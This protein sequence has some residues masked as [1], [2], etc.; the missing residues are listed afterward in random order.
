M[1][2]LIFLLTLLLMSSVVYSESEN[3]FPDKVL[4][5][6]QKLHQLLMNN[7]KGTPL[8]TQLDAIILLG[9]LRV[10]RAISLL[11]DIEDK[12]GDDNIRLEAK[13]ALYQILRV[14][15]LTGDN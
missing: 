11:E 14:E 15:G 2:K 12:S 8:G 13:N 6:D 5:D 7:V 10:E 1:K 4:S 9:D 3:Y